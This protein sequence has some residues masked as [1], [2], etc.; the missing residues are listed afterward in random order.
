MKT[1][2]SALAARLERSRRVASTPVLLKVEVRLTGRAYLAL[3]H[4]RFAGRRPCASE[5]SSWVQ[6]L[7]DADLRAVNGA[8]DGPIPLSLRRADIERRERAA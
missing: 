8:V 1:R 4:E 2:K 7:V 5:F 6:S 3:K